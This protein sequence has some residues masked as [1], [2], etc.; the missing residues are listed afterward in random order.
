[1]LPVSPNH[2][3]LHKCDTTGLMLRT[4]TKLGVLALRSEQIFTG[5]GASTHADRHFSAASPISVT[6]TVCVL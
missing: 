3:N 4:V 5:T 1:M 2:H 6:V